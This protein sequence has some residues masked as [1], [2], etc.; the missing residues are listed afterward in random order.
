MIKTLIFALAIAPLAISCVSTLKVRAPFERAFYSMGSNFTLTL[1]CTGEDACERAVEA[2]RTEVQRLDRVF[3]NYRDDSVLASLHTSG[4]EEPVPVPDEFVALTLE[5]KRLTGITAGAFDITVGALVELWKSA[6]RTGEP[7]SEEARL[8]A[9]GC[10]GYGALRFAEGRAELRSACVKLDYGAIGKGYAVDRVVAILR[11]AG[12]TSGLLDFGGNI[13]ALGAPPGGKGWEV[14]VR[15]PGGGE[16]PI[17]VLRLRDMAVATSGDYERYVTVG[18]RR[19][20]HIVDPRTGEPAEQ[21]ASSTV[22]AA[23]AATADAL[24]T[25]FSV[26]GEGAA[27]ELEERLEGAE[28]A[29]VMR[30]GRG[31]DGV[32]ISPGFAALMAGE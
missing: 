27:R 23:K 17:A 3:S 26:L 4:R 11:A 14:G 15:D 20:S 29:G 25:A 31:N 9:M 28:M 18:G 19:Y 30:I 5:S 2:V 32:Y 6:G 12:I 22:V 10:R 8:R 13:Y 21:V 16:A 1:Y 24:S 7:P